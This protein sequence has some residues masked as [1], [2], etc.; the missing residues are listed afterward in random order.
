MNKK[1]KEYYW[2]YFPVAV[3]YIYVT[4]FITVNCLTVSFHMCLTV[5]KQM[6]FNKEGFEMMTA[7]FVAVVTNFVWLLPPE[8]LQDLLEMDVLLLFSQNLSR[9]ML[10]QMFRNWCYLSFISF[11][12]LS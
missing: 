10:K 8:T 12:R 2:I 6:Q 4:Q 1:K 3:N 7:V 11:L 9:F 5:K